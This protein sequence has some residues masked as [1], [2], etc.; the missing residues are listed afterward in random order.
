MPERVKTDENA[1]ARFSSI[2]SRMQVKYTA[3]GRFDSRSVTVTR[4][5]FGGR[6]WTVFAP[7]IDQTYFQTLER[8]RRPGQQHDP[9]TGLSLTIT[10]LL[11]ELIAGGELELTSEPGKGSRFSVSLMLSSVSNGVQAVHPASIIEGYEGPPRTL[12]VVDDEP[13][14]R[15]LLLIFGPLN[16]SSLKP[17]MGQT[18]WKNWR[19]EP[20]AGLAS[21]SCPIGWELATAWRQ[22]TESPLQMPPNWPAYYNG[23]CRKPFQ[24]D[25]LL[26]SN[27]LTQLTW[28]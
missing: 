7:E 8:I 11:S 13:V 1:C 19:T 18:V 28:Q 6:R 21:I 20:T 23:L 4:W 14:L 12:M 24:L 10:K 27:W 5:P 26:Q 16:S 3:A 22:S 9:G 15:R 2:C 17:R 25:Q